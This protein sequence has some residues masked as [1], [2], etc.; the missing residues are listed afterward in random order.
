VRTPRLRQLLHMRVPARSLIDHRRVVLFWRSLEKDIG[1]GIDDEVDPGCIGSLPGAS[2]VA[3]SIATPDRRRPYRIH[4]HGGLNSKGAVDDLD[5]GPLLSQDES[6]FGGHR[7]VL[8]RRRMR[9]EP[10]PVGLIR[11]KALECDQAPRHVVGAFMRQEV[12]DEMTSALGNNPTPVPSVVRKRLALKRVD[13][14]AD[15]T[16]DR[17]AALSHVARRRQFV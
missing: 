5:E 1:S 6:L 9:S 3:S 11:G 7:E 14:I 2:D 15:E 17:H 8:T 12:P 16:G 10:R 4:S 13:L